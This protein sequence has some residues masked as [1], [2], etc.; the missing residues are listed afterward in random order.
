MYM[1]AYLA[2][3]IAVFQ[4]T[5]LPTNYCYFCILAL[6]KNSEDITSMY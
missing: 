4:N 5:A 3:E 1:E 6:I 2:K